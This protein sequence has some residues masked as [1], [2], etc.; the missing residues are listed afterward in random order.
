[1]KDKKR[2]FTL[3]ELL[4]VVLIIGILAAIALPFY[5]NNT[6]TSRW[7]EARITVKSLSDS[8]DRYVM[9][10]GTYP[11]SLADLDVEAP[12][13]SIYF[14]APVLDTATKYIKEQRTGKNAWLIKYSGDQNI[15][16][17]AANGDKADNDLCRLVTNDGTSA[18]CPPEPANTCYSL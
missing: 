4:V 5:S 18:P 11:S 7:S 13:V 3:I 1:M 12:A 8:V 2:A 17:A 6:E 14:N 16:C 15:Y 10:G 9:T